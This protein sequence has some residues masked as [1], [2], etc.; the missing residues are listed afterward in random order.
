MEKSADIY[1]LLVEGNHSLVIRTTQGQ[2]LT[3]DGRGVI[4][5]YRLYTR[6]PEILSGAEVADKAVGLGAA[7][8]MA[9][10]GISNLTTPVISEDALRLL[11]DNGVIVR[12]E[13]VA[14]YIINRLGNGRCPLEERLAPLQA[15]QP[16]DLLP[17]IEEFL[18]EKGLIG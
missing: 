1:T 8:L 15:Q 16:V 4:D 12:A 9:L 2:I 11:Q 6:N 14:P 18:A 7:T 5:L 3:F 13:V 17:T 10:G